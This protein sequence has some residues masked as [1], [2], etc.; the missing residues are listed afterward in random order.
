M[1]LIVNPHKIEIVKE[2]VNE[3]EVNITK[4]E[5]EFANEITN[6]FTKEAYFTFKG[7]TYKVIILN[8]ECDIP[9][10][11]LT[12]KGQVEL[13]V[14]AYKIENNEYVK[15]YNPSPVYFETWLGSLKEEVENSTTP[16]PS[17]LEQIT[18]LL[19]NKQDTLISGTN[20]K[21][22]N[23]QSLLGSGNI[24]IESGGTATNIDNRTITNNNNN[25]IQ[26]IGII[27]NNT[28][29]VDKMWI[30]I[31]QQY[32]AIQNKDAD[33]FYYITD[34]DTSITDIKVNNVSVLNNGVANIT[35]PTSLSQ[36]SEDTT[37]RIVTD[38][39]KQTWNNKS[40][41]SG[42][43]NDLSNKPT[44]PAEVTE[45]TVA[46]WGFTKNTGT[47]SKPSGGIP[48]TDLTSSVQTSLGKADTSIQPSDLTN[49]QLKPTVQ[50]I[51][52]TSATITPVDNTIYKCETLNSLT[53]T[54]PTSSGIY[55]IIFTS[56]S[57]ATTTVIPSSILGL[58]SFSAS[59]NTIYEINVYESRAVVG[60][61]V[62]TR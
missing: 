34:D 50:T 12:E 13:G 62:T 37:H 22:I 30:G 43:Y 49:Y 32:D 9:N 28:G 33:T 57:T 19:N 31:K 4:C 58:E 45:T 54:N 47:Y 23:D 41:F 1:K 36:L 25:E 7:T 3:K 29:N 2:P 11:V 51:T 61:W 17:E 38:T 55:S 44:I 27:D 40:N 24:T 48:K 6:E 59:A 39:E 16:T 26:T 42:S 21:T 56:G 35:V 20:I 15:R 8:N 46:N 52:G 53:I 18:S 10:E 5:F 60:S 14:V